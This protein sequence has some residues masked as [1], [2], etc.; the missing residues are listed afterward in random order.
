MIKQR[1]RG[2]STVTWGCIVAMLLLLA[3]PAPAGAAGPFVMLVEGDLLPQRVVFGDWQE[4]QVF[5]L[6]LNGVNNDDLSARPY[7]L[8]TLFWAPQWEGYVPEGKPVDA[9]TAAM[10]DQHLRFYPAVGVAPAVTTPDPPTPPG[11]SQPAAARI[12]GDAGLRVLQARGVPIVITP[13]QPAQSRWRA[14]WLAAL[15]GGA[16]LVLVGVGLAGTWARRKRRPR[17]AL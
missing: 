16:L 3:L 12:V 4:I 7:L 6:S 13:G 1:R 8:V 17:A 9:L 11:Y 15:V 2:R 5:Y 14:W 10:G